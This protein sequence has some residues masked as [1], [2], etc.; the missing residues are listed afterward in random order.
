MACL[1]LL[2]NACL[3]AAFADSA[4]PTGDE[5]TNSIGMTFVRIDPVHKNLRGRNGFSREDDD[6]VVFVSWYDAAGFCRWLS[7][8]E[9]VTYRLPT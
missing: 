2:L 9:G 3:T 7:D 5:F 8:K 1:A 6:A 4:M